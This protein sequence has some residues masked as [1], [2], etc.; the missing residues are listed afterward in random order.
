MTGASVQALQPCSDRPDRDHRD[1]IEILGA[2]INGPSFDP[3][4]RPDVIDV[5][6]D[7]PIYRWIC[8][9]D[10]CE[11]PRTGSTDLCGEHQQQ[12]S[13]QGA[14]GVGKAAFLLSAKGLRR[15]VRVEDVPCRICPDRPVVHSD[16]QLCKAHQRRWLRHTQ[17]IGQTC[18]FAEWCSRQA[19]LAGYGSCT[20]TVCLSRANSPLGLCGRHESGYHRD[21]RPGGAVLPDRWWHRFEQHGRPVPIEYAD[22]RAFRR[23]CATTPA[24]PFRGQINLLGLRPLVAA[25]LK[26]GLFISTRRSRPQRRDLGWIRSVVTACRDSEIDSL[27]GF[28]P[29]QSCPQMAATIIR[30]IQ[31]ELLLVY[32]T[33]ADTREAGFLETDH[34]GVRFPARGSHFDL[35][36]IPQRWLRGLVWDHLA[37]LLQSP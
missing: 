22:E 19:P 14:R 32:F 21:G 26:W 4:F 34:F 36:G 8:V 31:S 23:W 20:V 15:H 24:P 33:P 13:Q 28:E 10:R 12:L 1:R 7:H 35:T 3:M 25:E 27:V 5:P 6:P 30:Q 11:R 18:D 17:T 2:L 16:L 9:V 29:G 37:E